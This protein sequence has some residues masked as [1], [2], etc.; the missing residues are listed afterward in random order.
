MIQSLATTDPDRL[1]AFRNE[2][3]SVVAQYME[4]NLVR[5][6]YLLTRARKL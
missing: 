1:Q 6:D 3:E 2:F 5:Q 4:N